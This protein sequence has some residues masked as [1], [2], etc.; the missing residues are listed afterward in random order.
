MVGLLHSGKKR[1]K[2]DS[3]STYVTY[4]TPAW[5]LLEWIKEVYPHADFVRETW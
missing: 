5:R 2:F 3:T 4:A 1:N